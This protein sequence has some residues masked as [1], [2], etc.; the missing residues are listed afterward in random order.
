MVRDNKVYVV[1]HSGI[2]FKVLEVFTG[3]EQLLGL[4][5]IA[6]RAHLDKSAVQRSAHTLEK[7]G[8]LD[9]DPVSRRYMLGIR[10]LNPAF[11]YLRSHPLIEKA[12]PILL[13]LRRTTGERVDLSLLDRDALVYVLRLQSM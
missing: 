5:E 9:Q 12:A 1:Y 10:V 2:S 13:D 7:L 8:Y 11:G 6:S 4:S 3:R